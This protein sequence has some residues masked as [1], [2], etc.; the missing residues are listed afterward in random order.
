MR[1]PEKVSE[2]LRPEHEN[3][4]PRRVDDQALQSTETRSECSSNLNSELSG[5]PGTFLTEVQEVLGIADLGLVSKLFAQAANASKKGGIKEP[6]D[7]RYPLAIL[8]AI[9]PKDD[10]EALLAVQMVGT[11][12]LGMECLRK[13]SSADYSPVIESQLGCATKLLKLFNAQL[14]ALVRYRA[15]GLQ[16]MVVEHVKGGLEN[17]TTETWRHCWTRRHMPMAPNWQKPRRPTRYVRSETI[18]VANTPPCT[19]V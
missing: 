17:F 4:A 18:F 3:P 6:D 11:H 12:S 15:R 13:A 16:K 2:I 5:N 10:M 8:R 1:N 14:E 19:P 7:Y 9:G